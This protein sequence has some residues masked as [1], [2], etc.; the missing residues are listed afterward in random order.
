MIF[1]EAKLIRLAPMGDNEPK[2]I[3]KPSFRADSSSNVLAN[4]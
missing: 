3:E 2:N 4:Q 1:G